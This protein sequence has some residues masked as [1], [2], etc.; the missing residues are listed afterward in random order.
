MK[1]CPNCGG[2]YPSDYGLC[3][4]DGAPLQ[5]IS[6]IAVGMVLQGRYQIVAKLGEG[7]MGAVYKARHIHF[8]EL[9][10]L[11]VISPSLCEDVQF[12]E[13]FRTEALVMR[14][15]NH[16]NAVRVEDYDRTEDGRPLIVMEYV[17]GV[18]LDNLI[19]G[20]APFEPQRA[21]RIVLQVCDALAAAHRLDIVHRDIKPANILISKAQDGSEIAKVLD[22]GIAKVKEHG[23]LSQSSLTG[24]GMLVGTPAY[25][26]PEQILG[27]GRGQLDGRADLYSLGVVLYQLL[28][29]K[30]P[31][32]AAGPHELM[33]A[34]L[35]TPPRDPATLR[36]GLPPSLVAVVL[37]ALQKEPADRFASAEAMRAALAAC[38]AEMSEGAL[39]AGKYQILSKLGEGYMGP[40]YKARN[41][42]SHELRCLRVIS[43]KL[44]KAPGFLERFSWEAREMLRL[45]HPSVVHVA[46]I[47]QTEDG[48]PFTVTELVEGTPLDFLLAAGTPMEV[49]RATRLIMQV[50]DG[51]SAAHLL[52]IIHRNIVPSNILVTNDPDGNEVAKLLDF[53]LGIGAVQDTSDMLADSFGYMS[54]EEIRHGEVDRR[55]DIWSLGVVLFEMLTCKKPFGGAKALEA[56]LPISKPE[57]KSLLELR[58]GLSPSLLAVV[59]RAL[60]KEPAN[61]F[62][63]AKEMRDALAACASELNEG[64]VLGGKYQ[65]LAKLGDGW[66]GPLYKVQHLRSHQLLTLRV[67]SP[68]PATSGG[69]LD[70]VRSA[71]AALRGLVHPNVVRVE[72]YDQTEKARPFMVMEY[73]EGTSLEDLLSGGKA[74]EPRRAIQLILQVCAALGAAHRLGIM[75]GDIKPA[76]IL[77]TRGPDGSEIAKVREFGMDP[78]FL[79]SSTASGMLFA[80]IDCVSVER[81][82]GENASPRSDIWSVGVV[83]YN[84]LTGK[85]P[86]EGKNVSAVMFSI[87][88]KEPKPLRELRPDL[89]PRLVAVVHR[90]LEKDPAKRFSSVEEMSAALTACLGPG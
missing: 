86:F 89:P 2:T 60:S 50:C 46:D 38:A 55:S 6:G 39:L 79:N 62:P 18:S 19:A 67:I 32:A 21:I 70:R 37:R 65:I 12:L 84:L 13:R 26:S 40:V 85:M 82:R 45:N 64:A 28:T 4:K 30:G 10:A 27:A 87:I 68:A 16:P 74:L 77:L 9:R 34:H 25:M 47:D 3:P 41:V 78:L 43:P 83:L 54:P 1:T 24:T 66:M 63:S 11:K 57:P 23:S 69:F 75:H 80:D 15:L 36:A 76:M 20:E 17:E 5:S 44:C 73:I 90:A 14:R 33:I 56:G 29:G 42:H 58:P 61:R 72:D 31:F 35:S 81:I 8:D 53:A 49:H 52:G 59:Q 51:L 88:S 71:A 48:R 7:R 22:F